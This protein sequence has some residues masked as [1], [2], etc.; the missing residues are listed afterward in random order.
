ME[1]FVP[2]GENSDDDEETLEQEE[3]AA[4]AA[5]ENVKE[6]VDALKARWE[7]SLLV[8]FLGCCGLRP[9]LL[10]CHRCSV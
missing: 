6:E 2:D 5:G 8:L 9:G 1:E 10:R 4:A 3:A 7:S